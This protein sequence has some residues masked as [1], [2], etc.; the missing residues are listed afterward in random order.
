MPVE[1][2]GRL[3]DRCGLDARRRGSAGSRSSCEGI[4]ALPAPALLTWV[5]AAFAVIRYSQVE[6]AASPR[7][8]P[9]PFQARR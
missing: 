6:K 5:A 4:G 2:L 8:V 3:G 1:R 9:M 7:N